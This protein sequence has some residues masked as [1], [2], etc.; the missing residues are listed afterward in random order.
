MSPKEPIRIGVVGVSRGRTF[1]RGSEAATGL[2]LVALCDTWQERLEQ[3]R[4]E[5]A[6]RGTAVTTYTDYC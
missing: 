2:R 3:E 5:L 4:R 1:A 6:A